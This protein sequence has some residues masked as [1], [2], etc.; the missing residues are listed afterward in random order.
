MVIVGNSGRFNGRNLDTK[1]KK[2]ID[3]PEQLRK[4]MV[5]CAIK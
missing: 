5:N 4:G 1:R 3:F 2:V